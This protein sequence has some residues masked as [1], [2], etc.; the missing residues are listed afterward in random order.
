MKYNVIPT[1]KFI[2]DLDFYYRKKKYKKIE[3][4]ILE[5]TEQLEDG[6]LIGEELE[7]LGISIDESV[8]KVRAVN[9]SI[10]VGKS[11]GFRIIYYVVKNDNEIYLLTIYSKKD[12][13]TIEVN[14][15]KK[16]IKM[17]CI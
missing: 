11:N 15:I 3:K 10:N 16:L 1:Q 14:E 5:I 6:K 8:F 12:K 17:Y 7:E 2:K 4:D 13:E 9:S